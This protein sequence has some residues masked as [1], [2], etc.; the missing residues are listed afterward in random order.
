MRI[1]SAELSGIEWATGTNSTSNGPISSR[2][3]RL[4]DP[5]RN[6]RR[7]RLAEPPRFGEPGG[8]GRRVDLDAEARPQLGKRADMIL[9]RMG[10]DDADEILLHLLD[11][12]DVRHDEIDAG[13]VVAG[14]GDAEVDHQ[15]LARLRRAIAVERAIHSDFAQAPEGREHELAVVCHSVPAFPRMRSGRSR[16]GRA[17]RLRQ[18]PEIRGFDR[19]DPA[20]PAKQQTA[21]AVKPFER[22]LPPPAAGLDADA[23]AQSRRA[24]QPGGAHRV[25]P[26]ARAPCVERFAEPPDEPFE[27]RVRIDRAA[28]F[29]GQDGWSDS[30]PPRARS[31]S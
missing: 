5:E 25:E 23:P 19:F 7:A 29:R 1:A 4:D 14:E 15:P 2:V 30:R 16:H 28:A 8:E 24:R 26:L 3:A 13:Q 31:G 18:Y 9:V 27:K 6:F 11:E 17:I 12:A 20:L 21:G 10:D 22:P